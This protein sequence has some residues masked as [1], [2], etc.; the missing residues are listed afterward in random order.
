MFRSA[1]H[2]RKVVWA[3]PSAHLQAVH[4]IASQYMCACLASPEQG[5][6]TIYA[7]A[8]SMHSSQLNMQTTLDLVLLLLDDI[9]AGQAITPERTQQLRTILLNDDGVTLCFTFKTS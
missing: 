9:D 4:T 8:G 5:D 1:Q 7:H 2:L 6:A 3:V